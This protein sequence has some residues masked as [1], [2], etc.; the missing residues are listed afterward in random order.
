[1][2]RPIVAS[3]HNANIELSVV[4]TPDKALA[5]TNCAY[6]SPSQTNLLLDG[7]TSRATNW[8]MVKGQHVF[9]AVPHPQVQPGTI[10]LNTLQR[11]GLKISSG[12]SVPVAPWRPPQ[13]G[14]LELLSATFEIDVITKRKAEFKEIEIID[15]MY[16]RFADHVFTRDQVTLTEFQGLAVSILVKVLS[17]PNIE[18]KSEDDDVHSYIQ[19]GVLRSSSHIEIDAAKNKLLTLEK[20][21]KTKGSP[22][23]EW[24]FESLGIGGLDDQFGK[25]FRRAFSSRLYPPSLIAKLGIRHVR[26]ILLFGP[27]GTGKTLIARQIGKM[28]KGKEPKVVNGPEMLNKYVGASEENIRKLFADAEA[29]QAEKGDKSD[30]HVIIM[31]ELDAVCKQRG[32]GSD[33]T[34]VYDTIVNQLLSKLDGVNSL[35]N[36]LLIGKR[37]FFFISECWSVAIFLFRMGWWRFFFFI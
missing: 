23:K 33:S 11:E 18:A 9:C 8:V 28:L 7:A 24:D 36:I 4:S 1:M 6:V 27:P 2:S 15:F 20:D 3:Q 21:E 31:D 17:G 34:G 19:R 32:R 5:F 13:D 37:G 10:A 26:G 25:I 30:L 29:E 12:Q 35:N 14:S 16:E 22:F